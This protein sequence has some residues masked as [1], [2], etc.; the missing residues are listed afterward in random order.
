MLDYHHPM[1]VLRFYYNTNM[2]PLVNI[3]AISGTHHSQYVTLK[4][5]LTTVIWFFLM[6]L[7]TKSSILTVHFPHEFP[8]EWSFNWYYLHSWLQEKSFKIFDSNIS[9]GIIAFLVQ[10]N[11]DD[12]KWFKNSFQLRRFSFWRRFWYC[13]NSLQCQYVRVP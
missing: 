8:W 12:L 1:K 13:N 2:N 5:N 10:P 4:L 9:T 6:T 7:A 11:T 3:L